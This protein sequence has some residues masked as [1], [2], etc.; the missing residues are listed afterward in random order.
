MSQMFRRCTECDGERLFEQY[1]DEPGNCPDSPD[2]QCPEW[3][4]TECGDAL[5]ADLLSYHAEPAVTAHLPGK[6]A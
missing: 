4:C 5:L 3:A 1:H 6:V 2:G